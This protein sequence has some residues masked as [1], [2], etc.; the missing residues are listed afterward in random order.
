MTATP[1]PR[2][3]M[4]IGLLTALT[5]CGGPVPVRNAPQAVHPSPSAL[6]Q[7]AAFAAPAA[8]YAA[9]AGHHKHCA[10]HHGHCG[11]GGYGN[12]GSRPIID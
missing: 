9:P 10:A 6:A 5:A 4:A 2:A 8:T 12:D 1:A 11:H 3:F 7:G